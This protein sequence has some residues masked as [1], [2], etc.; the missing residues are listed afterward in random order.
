MPERKSKTK[1]A[2]PVQQSV[3]VDCSPEY[4]FRL[5]TERFA[6]WWPL[7]EG[8]EIEPF[9]GGKVL[10]HA[11]EGQEHQRGTVLTWDPPH[12]VE[13]R[14]HPDESS[15]P[16]QT[17]DQTVDVVFSRQAAGTR[18]TLTHRGWQNA[19]IEICSMAGSATRG[20]KKFVL[21]QLLVMA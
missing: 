14:W 12:R 17:D 19:G 18:V 9:E 1:K 10:E 13:F 15:G 6:E 20:F 4:A 7:G 8:C 21:E 5:F 2:E 3:Q 16:D 11:P